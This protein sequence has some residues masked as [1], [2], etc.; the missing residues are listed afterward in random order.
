[1]EDNFG[2]VVQFELLHDMRTVSLDGIHPSQLGGRFLV[3]F[4]SSQELR[5]LTF[6]DRSEGCR[7]PQDLFGRTLLRLQDGSTN[8]GSGI[9][10][11]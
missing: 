3:R 1:M 2:R 10:R 9:L 4:P 11:Q 8:L 5:Y 7:S 6:R